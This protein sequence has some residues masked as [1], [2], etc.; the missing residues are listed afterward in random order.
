MTELEYVL[1]QFEYRFR[2]H[3]GERIVLHGSR[4][5][6]RAILERFDSVFHFAGIMSRDPLDGPEFYGLPVLSEDALSGLEIDMVLLTE[7]VRYAEAVYQAIHPVC[8]E[9]GIR[10]FNMYGLDETELH[11]QV[12]ACQPLRAEQWKSVCAPYDIVVIEAVDTLLMVQRHTNRT[13]VRNCFR[14]LVPWLIGQGIDVRIS[15]RKSL[16]DGPQIEELKRTGLI[17][18]VEKRVIS[19]QGEDLSFRTLREDNPGKR[20]LHI[21]SGVVY[22]CILPRCYGIDTYRYVTYGC[23]APVGDP[24]RKPVPYDPNRPGEIRRLIRESDLVS[25]DVFDTLLLRQTLYPQD[26]FELVERKGKKL[27]YP[28]EGFSARRAEAEQEEEFASLDRIY[29]LLAARFGWDENTARIVQ[30][31]ELETERSVILPRREVA[32]LLGYAAGLG[33][34]IVLTSDMYLPAPVLDRI[35][36][37]NGVTGYEK[38]IVSCDYHKSKETGLMGE[39]RAL[40]GRD[41]RIL[42]IGDNPSADGDASELYG[43]RPVLIPS[44]V[45]LAGERGWAASI[46]AAESLTERCLV[47]MAVAEL[48]SDPFQD[49]NLKDRPAQERLRRFAAGVVAP[50][51]LGHTSWLADR[52]RRKEYDGVLFLSRDGYLPIRIY[53]MLPD[54]AQLPP[55]VYFYANRRSAF[56]GC[57]DDESR[58]E[59]MNQS[60]DY[61]HFS[62]YEKLSVLYGLPSGKIL[63]QRE[64]ETD[65]DYIQRH[66]P[67]ISAAAEEARKGYRAYSRHCGIRDGGTYAVVDMIATG[68]TQYSLSCYVP[69]R[70]EGYYYGNYNE[71]DR[72]CPDIE[73]YLTCG[74]PTLMANYME[75]ESYFTSPEPSVDHISPQGEV[76]LAKEVRPPEEIRS[77]L[78]V[79]RQAEQFAERFLSLFYS[80]GD[81]IDPRVPEEMF[82]AEGYHWVRFGSFDDWAKTQI[83]T[84]NWRD[85][86][87]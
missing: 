42:H 19:R 86:G 64:G 51:V 79:H 4:E 80:E 22:E 17:P 67:A 72:A 14:L 40:A 18:D 9:R 15:L 41:A 46:R 28:A 13:V 3:A 44:P 57:A 12:D 2:E 59:M 77:V 69:W 81:V 52:L 53:R 65:T 31:L 45:R 85:A 38:L 33:K 7:R 32:D 35:L 25:F 74:N 55:P 24:E 5:Y 34:R 39:V 21:G 75:L 30:S 58:I 29:E 49:P 50:L 70:M 26:V 20:I 83:A 78:F 71:D 27:G 68:S 36:K 82:A 23:L 66:M 43:I 84:K 10:I 73:D 87:Q 63:P 37:E 8:R 60:G 16:P 61:Y 47:G 48:F 1:S 56:F 54:A 6:A 76:V 62:N 11:R